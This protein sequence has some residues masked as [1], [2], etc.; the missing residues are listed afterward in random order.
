[1]KNQSDARRKLRALQKERRI[2][3]NACE[4]GLGYVRPPHFRLHDVCGSCGDTYYVDIPN[5]FR[6][7]DADEIDLASY[8]FHYS[9]EYITAII[10]TST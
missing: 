8:V 5:I 4:E 7:F 9:D 6:D 3:P 10:E 1:M 2:E